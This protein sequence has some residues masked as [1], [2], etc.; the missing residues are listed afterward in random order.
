MVLSWR[1]SCA[2]PLLCGKV[3]GGLAP[4]P[5][6]DD[7]LLDVHTGPARGTTAS[8]RAATRGCRCP[9]RSTSR[10]TS[11]RRLLYGRRTSRSSA[12]A[13]TS[14][15]RTPPRRSARGRS[16]RGLTSNGALMHGRR[17]RPPPECRRSATCMSLCSGVERSCGLILSK[18]PHRILPEPKGELLPKPLRVD[19]RQHRH[20]LHGRVRPRRH[21]R[22]S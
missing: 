1:P 8:R 5:G 3:Y 22:I 20:D 16:G 2:R 10:K 18:I 15:R 4:F 14:G 9:T 12:A 6:Y 21:L 13:T 11:R 17:A 7:S 19:A